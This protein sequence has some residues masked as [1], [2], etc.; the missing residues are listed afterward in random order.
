MKQSY[1]YS[2]IEWL[3]VTDSTNL[4]VRRRMGALDN[5]SV[6]A[7]RLQTSG[8]GRGAHHWISPEGENLTFSILLRFGRGGFALLPAA[9]AVRITQ[10]ATVSVYEFLLSEGVRARIKWP[11]D[12]WV[13]DRKI[14]GMLI[15]NIL[16]GDSVASSIVG[17]GLNLNQ[18]LFNPCLPNPVSLSQLTGNKYD[19]KTSLQALYKIFCRQ[20]ALLDSADGRYELESRF[21]DN[22]FYLD[23]GSQD[24]FDR[25]IED[26][27]AAQSSLQGRKL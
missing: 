19:T 20:A 1:D 13:G 7:S 22:L 5:L 3:D 17:I 15:E 21:K 4:E 11:N 12:I 14:C 16:D 26:F 2:N 23:K 25:A 9:E 18:K 24:D 27:E 8:R 6:I 10:L